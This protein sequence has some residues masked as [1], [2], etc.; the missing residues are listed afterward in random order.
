MSITGSSSGD[1]LSLPAPP[2]GTP[3]WG[4]LEARVE[5]PLGGCGSGYAPAREGRGADCFAFC[6]ALPKAVT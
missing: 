4:Y 1:A 2:I 5:L 3:S 6:F